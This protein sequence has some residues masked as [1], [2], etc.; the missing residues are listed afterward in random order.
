MEFS[1]IQDMCYTN[2]PYTGAL[3]CGLEDLCDNYETIQ[4]FCLTEEIDF[5]IIIDNLN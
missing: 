4:D 3:S 1:S 2:S 5:A